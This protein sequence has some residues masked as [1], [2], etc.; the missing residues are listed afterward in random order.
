MG[1]LLHISTEEFL[2]E[3]LDTSFPGLERIP[4]LLEEGKI[5]DAKRE[6]AG[7]VR[8]NLR[9]DRYFRI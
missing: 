9:P 3:K 2:K 6:Y 5:E 7:F 8:R 1:E 4:R